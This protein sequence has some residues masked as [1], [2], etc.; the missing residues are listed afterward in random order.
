LYG[1]KPN[2]KVLS[3]DLDGFRLDADSGKRLYHYMD[4]EEAKRWRADNFGPYTIVVT[5]AEESLGEKVIRL[6]ENDWE[7]LVKVEPAAGLPEP[8]DHTGELHVERTVAGKGP[9]LVHSIVESWLRTE[10]AKIADSKSPVMV[11]ATHGSLARQTWGPKGKK[12]LTFEFEP[13]PG[14]GT[15]IKLTVGTNLAELDWIDRFGMADRIY[16]AWEQFLGGLWDR[17][18][19]KRLAVAPPVDLE[20]TRLRLARGRIAMAGGI[21]VHVASIVISL[22]IVAAFGYGGPISFVGRIMQAVALT[23]GIA[24]FYGFIQ[25]WGARRTLMLR[26]ASDPGPGRH[27]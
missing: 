11:R 6:S 19:E 20:A 26:H 27:T 10:K 15:R 1:V 13:A 24:A 17:L 7:R 5:F 25:W 2:R 9:D 14:G 16:F 22:L 12:H 21:A 8:E 18:G 3:A 23:G 4:V